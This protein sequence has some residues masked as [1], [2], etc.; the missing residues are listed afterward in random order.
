[1]SYMGP[2]LSF[3]VPLQ[4]RKRVH[5]LGFLVWLCCGAHMRPP[6]GT[7]TACRARQRLP[8]S[9]LHVQ[10]YRLHFFS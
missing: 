8:S 1:M 4:S 3:G 2:P 9:R 10:S 6:C 7:F 5:N